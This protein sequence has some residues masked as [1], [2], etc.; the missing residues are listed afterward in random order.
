MPDFERITRDIEIHF[1]PNETELRIIKARHAGEDRARR[2]VAW[3][4]AFIA[5][6]V[7][8]IH[9]YLASN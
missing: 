3:L 8:A 6:I 9:L 2:Q 5:G 7:T 1:A 4:A